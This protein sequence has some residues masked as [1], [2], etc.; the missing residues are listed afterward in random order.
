[1]YINF[2]SCIQTH[3]HKTYLAKARVTTEQKKVSIRTVILI[4]QMLPQSN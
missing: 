2:G 1:M 4:F 3:T